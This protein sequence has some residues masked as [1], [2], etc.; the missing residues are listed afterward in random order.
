MS[1]TLS[2]RGLY[3]MNESL[4][5][6]MTMP[7]GMTV[8]DRDII[9]DNIL[10]EFAE[11]EV[12]YPDPVFMQDAIGKWSH[13]EVGTWARIYRASIADYNPIENYNRTETYTETGSNSEHLSGSDSEAHTGTDTEKHSGSD[14]STTN[15]LSSITGLDSDTDS[16]TD[17]ITT[18]RAGFDSNQLVTTGTDSTQ[19]G[20]VLTKSISESTNERGSASVSHGKNIGFQHGETVTTNYGRTNTGNNT[21]SRSGNVSGNI[22]VTTSQQMLEQELIVSAK[23]NVYNYIMES[24][25]N[26]FCLE[27]Y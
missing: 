25:K 10:N 7:D 2:I 5:T 12:I 3:I 20:H 8:A 17:T 15:S 9:V 24:F 18:N 13:K 4:F 6:E 26:R 27:V 23:L 11:L 19:H 1:A 22:G 14:T 21:I 16:G